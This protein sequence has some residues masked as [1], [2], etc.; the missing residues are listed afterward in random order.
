LRKQWQTVVLKLIRNG[1]SPR[2]KKR[3]QP[4]LQKAFTNNGEGFYVFF[5][6]RK[7]RKMQRNLHRLAASIYIKSHPMF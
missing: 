7:C 6:S 1:V 4:R 5:A 3:I 2:E